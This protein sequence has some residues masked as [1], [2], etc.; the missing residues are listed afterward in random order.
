MS[1]PNEGK[2]KVLLYGTGF[3]GLKEEVLV[4]W[5]VLYTET[6]LKE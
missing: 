3:S 5:G 1:G 6:M 4:K 2:T